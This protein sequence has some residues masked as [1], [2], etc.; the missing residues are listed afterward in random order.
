MITINDVTATV[1]RVVLAP[2][3]VSYVSLFS[4]DV[5]SFAYNAQN[6]E[7]VATKP[8]PDYL[9]FIQYLDKADTAYTWDSA[10]QAPVFYRAQTDVYSYLVA[11]WFTIDSPMANADYMA[12]TCGW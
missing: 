9:L 11:P 4:P 12:P 8:T 7:T 5:I 10:A 1:D 2:L 3:G 6:P